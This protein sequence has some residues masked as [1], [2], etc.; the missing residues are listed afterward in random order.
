MAPLSQ[1]G[2]KDVTVVKLSIA[3]TVIE[4]NLG[5]EKD[6][7]WVH[8]VFWSVGGGNIITYLTFLT[9][10]ILYYKEADILCI[11]ISSLSW[12]VAF[13]SLQ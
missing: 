9:Y 4:I 7:L 11:W 6:H 12:W 1:S 5:M 3:N 13:K 2:G 10:N 8:I